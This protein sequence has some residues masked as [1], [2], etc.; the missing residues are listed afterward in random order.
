MHYQKNS[1]EYCFK[2]IKKGMHLLS[3]EFAN[4]AKP[5]WVFRAQITVL[6]HPTA[7]KVGYQT[8]VHIGFIKTPVSIIDIKKNNGTKD[9]QTNNN[10]TKGPVLVTGDCAEVE[11]HFMCRPQYIEVGTSLLFRERKTKAVGEILSV[12]SD[13]K[14]NIENN[15]LKKI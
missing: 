12:S 8:V 14:Y 15:R 2:K 4:T 13:K 6:R 3:T 1:L 5:L 10:N 7:I 11:M 9:D